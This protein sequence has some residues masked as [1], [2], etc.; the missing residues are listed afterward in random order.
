VSAGLLKRS[1]TRRR[2]ETA[3]ITGRCPVCP[4]YPVRLRRSALSR[5]SSRRRIHAPTGEA[6]SRGARNG[7]AAIRDALDAFASSNPGKTPPLEH[8]KRRPR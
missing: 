4:R 5:A 3:A 1:P 2:V 7:D 6:G 8:S